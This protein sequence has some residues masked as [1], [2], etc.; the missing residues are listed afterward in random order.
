MFNG[1]IKIKLN[2]YDSQKLKTKI[3]SN[4]SIA[5]CTYNGELFL[6]EQ[7]ESIATQTVLPNEVIISDDNSTDATLKILREFQEK[8][9]LN[10]KI[11]RNK[12]RFGY[13]KNFE[14]AISLCRG[15]I[16]FIADQDDVWLPYKLEKIIDVF[17]KYP[18]IGY[19]FSD[20]LIVNEKL[21]NHGYTMWERI[22]FTMRQRRVFRYRDQLEVLLKHNV[23]TGPTMAFRGE[24]RK[25]I[26]PIPEKWVHDAWIALL[27]S[28]MQQKGAII[29]EVLIKYRQHPNQSVGAKKLSFVRQ[30]QKAYHSGSNYFETLSNNFKDILN[31]LILT[32]KLKQNNRLLINSK[33]EHLKARR[34][35]HRVQHR[36]RFY[37]IF[38]ELLNNR[39]QRFSNGWKSA[40]KD[41]F[42]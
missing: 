15:S 29:E 40:A 19:V 27:L 24:L 26:L 17:K 2:I 21:Q 7:L 39:Y 12:S 11:F 5:M 25:L 34:D 18:K 38:K 14:R 6:Q 28:A 33:I 8:N 16:I 42:L 41:M 9:L 30:V 36:K 20:A 13:T 23:V 4:I 31:R 22:S 37:W 3:N 1:G 10:L 35:M 32:N